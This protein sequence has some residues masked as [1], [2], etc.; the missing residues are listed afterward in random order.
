MLTGI[1]QRAHLLAL[2]CPR[3]APLVPTSASARGHHSVRTCAEEASPPRAKTITS[4]GSKKRVL[5]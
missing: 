5:R 1:V 2:S 3:A 4:W